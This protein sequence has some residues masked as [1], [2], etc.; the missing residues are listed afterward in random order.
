MITKLMRAI[1]W[2]NV[3]RHSRNGDVAS[4]LYSLRK[5]GAWSPLKLYER[6][7]EGVLLLRSRDFSGAKK[8]FLGVIDYVGD[9]KP[10]TMYAQ[11]YA[12]AMLHGMDGDFRREREAWAE[13]AAVPCDPTLRRWLP[14]QE[15]SNILQ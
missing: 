3:M 7:F 6:T 13:A 1:H 12:K 9:T 5:A 11:A 10:N 14:L 4:S 8:A 15:A 2:A